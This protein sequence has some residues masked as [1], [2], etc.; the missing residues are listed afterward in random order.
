VATPEYAISGCLLPN[1]ARNLFTAAIKM[2][3]FASQELT[4]PHL[5][6][7]IPS[8]LVQLFPQHLAAH[9]DPPEVRA[10]W[11]RLYWKVVRKPKRNAN[12]KH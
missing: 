12:R 7:M 1:L 4:R 11:L 6:R 8:P 2:K 10:A 9:Q 3:T 5:L